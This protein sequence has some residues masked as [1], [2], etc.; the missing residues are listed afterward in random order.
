MARKLPQLQRVLDAPGARIRCIRRDRLVDLLRARHHRAARA[1]PDSRRA[2]RRRPALPRRR[3]VVRRGNRVDSRDRRRGDVRP[4]CLQRL[5]RLPHRLGAVPRLP[6]RDRALRAVLPALPRSR[7]RDRRHRA[8][9]RRRHLRVHPHRAHRRVA[10][11]PPDEALHLR[12][13]G[14]P[15][16]PRHAAAARDPRLRAPLLLAGSHAGALDRNVAVVARDRVRA[17]ARDARLHR[18]RDGRQS[19]RGSPSPGTR[20]AAQ[21]LQRDLGRR[22]DLR[23]DRARRALGVPGRARHDGARH[24]LAAFAADGNRCRGAAA[25]AALVRPGAEASTSGSRVRSCCSRLRRRRSPV[26]AGS[27]TPSASTASCRARSGASI[28]ARS[29]RRS[30]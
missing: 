7:A 8:A 6:D 18:P 3:A 13:R 26:S 21:P 30:R 11:H 25:R 14:R 9:S 17:A 22:R 15:A 23:A 27:P 29:S 10:P 19:R 24:R 28:A 16:R 12:H 20:S 5:R 4:R 1:R 2:R